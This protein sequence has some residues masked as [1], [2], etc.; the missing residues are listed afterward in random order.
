M[1]D[2]GFLVDVVGGVPVVVAPEE[3]DITNAEALGSALLQGGRERP[4]P[5]RGGHDPDPSSAIRPGRMPWPPR[6]SAPKP[7]AA[8]C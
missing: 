2:D 3:I 1:P 5:A 8:R 4:R 6:T 7:R